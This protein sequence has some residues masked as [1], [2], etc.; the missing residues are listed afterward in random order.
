MTDYR[1]HVTGDAPT[2]M[3]GYGDVPEPAIDPGVRA[4]AEAVRAAIASST[5]C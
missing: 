1:E 5:E 3:L 4:V 2:L